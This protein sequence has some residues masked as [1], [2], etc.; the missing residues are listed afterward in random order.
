MV[1]G[2][3]FEDPKDFL[4]NFFMRGVSTVFSEARFWIVL[5]FITHGALK[6]FLAWGLLKKKVWAYPVS[7]AVF[8]LFITV[9]SYRLFSPSVHSVGGRYC[10]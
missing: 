7:I 2:E 6:L 9:Q 4:A 1:E 10:F 5:F 8:L 3:L